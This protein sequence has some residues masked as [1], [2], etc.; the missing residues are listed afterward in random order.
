MCFTWILNS[1]FDKIWGSFVIYI[2]FNPVKKHEQG[3]LKF[4]NILSYLYSW[5]L[6]RQQKLSNTI[7]NYSQGVN[8]FVVCWIVVG[9]VSVQTVWHFPCLNLCRQSTN[10]V[11]TS[12][13]TL[14]KS[15]A[16][17]LFTTNVRSVHLKM[18]K[19]Y[20]LDL[21]VISVLT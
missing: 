3:Q 13:F 1:S 15:S 9:V 19:W 14:V 6:S 4:K 5:L 11:F 8:V 10:S 18:T 2:K 21:F 20:Y 7:H 16:L 12:K 17:W